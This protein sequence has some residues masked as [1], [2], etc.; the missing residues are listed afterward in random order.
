MCELLQKRNKVQYR[1][2][3]ALHTRTQSH[4]CVL[5]ERKEDTAA[6]ARRE[7]TSE[8]YGGCST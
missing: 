3:H 7:L 6:E 5:V 8:D 4:A 1:C 2:I